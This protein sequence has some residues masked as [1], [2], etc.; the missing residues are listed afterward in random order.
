M[1]CV[2]LL[3]SSKVTG[4]FGRPEF[5]FPTIIGLAIAVLGSAS[6]WLV[7]FATGALVDGDVGFEAKGGVEEETGVGADAELAAS[8]LP[9]AGVDIHRPLKDPL[10]EQ[11]ESNL[12]LKDD[13]VNADDL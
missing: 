6:D 3:T 8:D 5:T 2:A 11:R 7:G 12:D 9:V 4:I 10:N 13:R 1:S